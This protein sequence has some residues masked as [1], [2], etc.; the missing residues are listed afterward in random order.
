[1][2]TYGDEVQSGLTPVVYL[3][4]NSDRYHHV[5]GIFSSQDKAE[6]V[7][8]AVANQYFGAEH[9]PALKWT[10]HGGHSSASYQHPA[11]G[12]WFFQ[13]TGFTVDEEHTDE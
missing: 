13:V 6:A 8:Q 3:A 2:D 5:Y 1:M 9:T 12:T 11:A 4:E 10:R 7:C